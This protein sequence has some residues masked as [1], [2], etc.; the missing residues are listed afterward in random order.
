MHQDSEWKKNPHILD[1]FDIWED[2]SKPTF[3]YTAISVSLY[4]GIFVRMTITKCLVHSPSRIPM[5][6]L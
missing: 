4:G 2:E 3:L 1:Q 6:P 5:S